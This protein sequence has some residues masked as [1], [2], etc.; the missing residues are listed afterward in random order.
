[1]SY[2][3]VG[4]L[5]IYDG[6]DQ[7][8]WSAIP[9]EHY[10]FS[11][12]EATIN[13]T[14]PQGFAPREGVDPVETY[15][16]PATVDVRGTLITAA[17]TRTLGGSDYF[18][19]RVQYPHDPNAVP[20]RWQS[21]F[22]SQ[23]AF[24]ETTQPIISIVLL[25][26]SL[27]IGI[28]LP[29]YIYSL[30]LR[31][32]RDPKIGPVPTYLE[33]PPSTMPPALVGTLVD[34][35]ADLRDVLSTILDLGNRGYLVIEESQ[36]E[37]LF[38]LGRSSAFVF[39]RTDQPIDGGE[40]WSFERRFLVNLFGNN[41]MERTMESLRTVFYTVIAQMQN[42]LYQ[43]LVKQQLYKQNPNSS[44]NGWMGISI[45]LFVVAGLLFYGALEYASTISPM[46]Y[47]IPVGVGIGAIAALIFSG[48]MS[49]RTQKGAEESAKWKAFVEYL[50]N[51]EK[52]SSV[53]SAAA[54]F[55]SFLPYAVSAGIDRNWINRFKNVQN[56]YVPVPTWYYPTYLGPW[57]GGYH[58]GS[59]LPRAQMSQPG[60]GLPGDLAR[61]GGS[62]GLDQ[63][64]GGLA[65]GL[66]SISNGLTS[67]LN[68]AGQAMT[69]QPQPQSSSSGHWSSG[70][71]SWSGGGFRGGG[72]SGGGRRGF[73]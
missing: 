71:R 4:A 49:S 52:Y 54:R 46:L 64:S 25:I 37:G 42:D 56:T 15:G 61:A 1:M 35:R 2:T 69:S 23:R 31:N 13:V 27:A 17:A 70:G 12:G 21:S 8:W 28:G 26:V 57:R 16:A 68:S 5:R 41:R 22:D 63:L 53:E 33:E 24:E 34:G 50:R 60:G 6:G 47:G 32:G 59:P 20:P 40:L 14:M 19:I 67:M 18:E 55:A 10:G 73:G 44:R 3:V 43:E 11:I 29:L 72:S 7:L 39:K 65:N 66:E 62:G 48:S 51:L 36:S 9:A 38:G 30:H 58:A 45:G